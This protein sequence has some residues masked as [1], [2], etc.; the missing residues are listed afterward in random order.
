MSLLE[1]DYDPVSRSRTGIYEDPDDEN[2][3][4]IAQQADIEPVLRLNYERRKMVDENARWTLRGGDDR[5]V[6]EMVASIPA[7]VYYSLPKHLRDDNNELL[8][9]LEQSDQAVFRTRAGRLR[10]RLDGRGA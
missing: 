6:G 4:I 3:L 9:W 1:L 7:S 10:T 8:R 2:K 5:G